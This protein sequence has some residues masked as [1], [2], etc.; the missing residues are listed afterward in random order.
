MPVKAVAIALLIASTM[1]SALAGQAEHGTICV[2]AQP[3]ELKPGVMTPG[4]EYNPA[5]LKFRI[6]K[7]AVI[8]WPHEKSVKIEGLNTTERHLIVIYSDGKQIQ[9]ARFR[10]ADF[11]NSYVCFFYDGYGG[12]QLHGE[13]HSVCKC[14]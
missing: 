11:E 8:S 10:F 7:G 14:K 4:D 5:T 1:C 2:Q 3:A 12:I 13:K 6:D 9:S